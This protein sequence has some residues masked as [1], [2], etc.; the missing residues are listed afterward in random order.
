MSGLDEAGTFRV[1][2]ASAAAVGLLGLLQTLLLAT[3][4]PLA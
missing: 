4:L 2:S 1:W 3:L